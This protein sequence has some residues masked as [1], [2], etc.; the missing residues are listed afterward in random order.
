M[1]RWALFDLDDTLYPAQCGLWGAI[2]RRIDQYM[3]ERLGLPRE[4]ALLDRQR[5]LEVFGTTLNGLVAEHAIDP[6]DYLAFVHNVPLLDYLAP[7]PALGAM[8]AR[9]PLRKAVFTNADAA[10]ARRVLDCLGVA[11]H[12]EH[13]ID[14]VALDYI[15][16]PDPRAYARALRLLE[17]EAHEC[18]FIDDAPRN[19]RPAHALG[20]TTVMVRQGATEAPPGVDHVVGD[21]LGVEAVVRAPG[22]GPP[23]VR[24]TKGEA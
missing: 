2:G 23:S 1:L 19:L 16:K 24:T 10:H 17:A 15:N 4:T 13:I 8:L 18:A 9:L 21:V 12:F 14:I 20:M 11:A 22:N 3:A 7:A 6:Q 5:Y